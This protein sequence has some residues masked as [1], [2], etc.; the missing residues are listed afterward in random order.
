[1]ITETEIAIQVAK[2]LKLPSS[3]NL[4]I[5]TVI[6]NA[7]NEVAREAANDYQKRRLLVSDNITV[8]LSGTS[9]PY[10]ADTA[11]SQ[12]NFGLMLDYLQ[13][14]DISHTPAEKTFL[15]S[16]VD[17]ASDRISLANHGFYT[18]L[19][20]RFS[21]TDTLPSPLSASTDYYV[22][23][24]SANVIKVATT[25]DNAYNGTAIDLLAQGAGTDTISPQE[26]RLLQWIDA[27]DFGQL[28][29]A[30]PLEYVYCW[31]IRN[32]LYVSQNAT[33][34]TLTFAVPYI[35]TLDTISPQLV[36][37][38]IDACVALLEQPNE[39]RTEATR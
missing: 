38:L 31:L 2:R 18:G 12:E 4:S 36:N 27:P 39:P 17:T 3:A 9:A 32:K 6:P 8:N 21:T 5:Q 7:L 16:A 20:V 33:T 14:G 24:T 28:A 26:S 15:F 19:K 10:Y 23:A 29:S 37:D 13:Y 34:G 11:S 35:P 25:S 22:I 30:I 1:M